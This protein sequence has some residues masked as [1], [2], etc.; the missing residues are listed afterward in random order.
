VRLELCHARHQSFPLVI[1]V[2]VDDGE[3]M[4][5]LY[6]LQTQTH[7]SIQVFSLPPEH[8]EEGDGLCII[9]VDGEVE[10]LRLNLSAV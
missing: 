3:A 1:P 9:G 6:W 4:V 8:L 2:K 7:H 5:T 10:Q